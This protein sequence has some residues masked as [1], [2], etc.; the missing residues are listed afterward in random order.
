[1]YVLEISGFLRPAR[2][3]KLEAKWKKQVSLSC[4]WVRISSHFS[5]HILLGKIYLLSIS[6]EA[7]A[8]RLPFAFQI[9]LK[10]RYW[11][12]SF[13]MAIHGVPDT[14]YSIIKRPLIISWLEKWNVQHLRTSRGMPAYFS[15]FNEL[16]GKVLR[17]AVSKAFKGHDS[18]PKV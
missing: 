4:D 7:E 10:G 8:R 18:V 3:L 5:H 13:K 15:W 16:G 1:M 12:K 14:D 2:S 11:F 9:E 6:I 17:H